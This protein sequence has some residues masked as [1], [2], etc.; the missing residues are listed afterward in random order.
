MIKIILFF[1]IKRRILKFND[2]SKIVWKKNY[3]SKSEKKLNKIQ[4]ANNKKILVIVDNI[5]KYYAINI[6]TG[7]LLWSKNNR[8]PFN[9]Q[10]KIYKDKFFSVDLENVIRCFS[11]KDGSEIWNVKTD[12]STN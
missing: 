3:Y 7:E 9:S 6:K 12:P 1:L 5:T 4:F 10:V 8:A 11:L 2:N